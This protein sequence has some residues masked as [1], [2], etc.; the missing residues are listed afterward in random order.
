MGNIKDIVDLTR[1]LANSVEDRRFADDLFKI[2]D[3]VLA[4]KTDQSALEEENRQLEADN[5]KLRELNS[6]LEASI[7]ELEEKISNL[8]DPGSDEA[9][10]VSD[11]AIQVLLHCSRPGDGTSVPEVSRHLEISEQKSNSRN[12]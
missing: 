7:A 4:V 3:L 8:P 6:S 2:V 1:D 11:L 10:G 12:Q 5:S 9:N